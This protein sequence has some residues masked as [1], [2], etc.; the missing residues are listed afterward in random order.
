MGCT[1]KSYFRL[2]RRMYKIPLIGDVMVFSS[3]LVFRLII[4]PSLWLLGYQ[5]FKYGTVTIWTPKN[6][7]NAILEGMDFLKQ[8]DS[9]VYSRIITKSNLFIYYCGRL[10]S[11][12][13]YGHIF[14]LGEYFF[15]SGVQGIAVFFVQSLFLS[16]AA[17]SINQFRSNNGRQVKTAAL[18]KVAN[19]MDKHSFQSE[20]INS[21]H[22][23]IKKWETQ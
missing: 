14:A 3:Y 18:W 23:M 7:R 11:T 1:Q 9:E 13:G 20:L 2:V 17:P 15:T 10:K 8:C 16:E 12:S 4:L 5:R 6:K 21:Y 19:W 22:T